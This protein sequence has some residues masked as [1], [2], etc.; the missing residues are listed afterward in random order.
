MMIQAATHHIISA[1][2]NIQSIQG[3]KPFRDQLTLG[4]APPAKPALVVAV[5][6]SMTIGWFMRADE[7]PLAEPMPAPFSPRVLILLFFYCNEYDNMV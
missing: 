1:Q 4:L 5:P 6:T 2:L 7:V 3:D